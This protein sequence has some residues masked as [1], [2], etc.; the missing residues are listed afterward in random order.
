[1]EIEGVTLK[2]KQQNQNRNMSNT[3]NAGKVVTVEQ[4]EEAAKVARNMKNLQEDL[5]VMQERLTGLLSG[6]V[7]V[8][9]NGSPVAGS[10]TGAPKTRKKRGPVSEETRKNMQR[11]AQKRWAAEAAAKAAKEGAGTVT[12]P[13]VVPEQVEVAA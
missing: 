6:S 8:S 9:P 10:A 3:A 4:L 12:I 11:G 13:T 2:R 7:A 1:M 5:K